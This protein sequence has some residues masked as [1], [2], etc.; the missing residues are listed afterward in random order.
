MATSSDTPIKISVIIPVW[1]EGEAIHQTLQ[2]LRQ[3]AAG[4][5]HEVIVVDGDARGSTITQLQPSVQN[6]RTLI[7]SPG[8]GI[9]LNAGAR[10]ARGE[11]L[12]FLHADTRLPPL[13]L[14]NICSLLDKKT[15][16][17]GAFNLGINSPS[18]SLKL[19][20]RTASL[21]SRLTRI[22]YG[23]QG[24]FIR[25]EYFQHIGGFPEIPIMEDI[26]LMRKIKRHKGQIYI[27][28]E[29]V[30][31][32]PRRWEQEGVVYCTLRNWFLILMYYAGVNPHRLVA[33][34]RPS[35][36]LK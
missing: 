32:S 19:I 27:F 17:G 10:Q 21:R 15:Y 22:P 7:T 35:R 18:F 12:L 1:G 36:Y 6:V 26:A 23:D 2:G 13:A 33:W 4:V 8:R 9:Q 30:F 3:C 34:Y 25:R 20:A 29:R 31:V 16:V 5:T 11:V 24:V 28:P 14:C